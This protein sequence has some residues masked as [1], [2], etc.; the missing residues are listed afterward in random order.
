M[1]IRRI[2]VGKEKKIFGL[3]QV[4]IQTKTNLNDG[5]KETVDVSERNTIT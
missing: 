4:E 1:P 3:K 5:K 2:N